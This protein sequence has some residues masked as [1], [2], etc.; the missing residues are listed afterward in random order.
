MFIQRRGES[1][2]ANSFFFT[3]EPVFQASRERSRAAIRA[4]P[5]TS[6]RSRIVNLIFP[7]SFLTGTT[8]CPMLSVLPR[9]R[10]PHLVFSLLDETTPSLVR[11][12]D[13]LSAMRTVRALLPVLNPALRET[14]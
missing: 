1:M 4:W 6:I 14:S 10:I 13:L 5:T 8:V 3:I 2:C 12:S 9:R 11:S 7:G